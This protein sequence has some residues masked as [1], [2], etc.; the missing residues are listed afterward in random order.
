MFRRRSEIENFPAVA[1]AGKV[2]ATA[3]RLAIG[4]PA[5]TR[6]TAALKTRFGA[7]LFER[8]PAGVRPAAPGTVAAVRTRRSLRAYEEPEDRPDEAGAGVRPASQNGDAAARLSRRTGRLSPRGMDSPA[9]GIFLLCRARP[10]WKAA[11]GS[12]GPLA[13]YFPPPVL[14]QSAAR[15]GGSKDRQR[16][17]RAPVPDR[18]AAHVRT[19]APCREGG[20]VRAATGLQVLRGRRRGGMPRHDVRHDCRYRSGLR[21]HSMVGKRPRRARH[22]CA[23]RRRIGLPLADGFGASGRAGGG[24][25]GIAPGGTE[26]EFRDSVRRRCL[27]SGN[28]GNYKYLHPSPGGA[29]RVFRVPVDP[30]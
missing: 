26:R 13:P 12:A 22:C 15:R 17:K 7:P 23:G 25:A 11:A 6:A 3:D 19:A 18:S 20:R 21:L 29:D 4:Q 8:L 14:P 16:C 24:L 30:R 10:S 5:L 27:Q 1:E 2:V 9:N 28:P